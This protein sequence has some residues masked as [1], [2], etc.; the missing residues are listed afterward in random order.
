M[1]RQNWRLQ[2]QRVEEGTELQPNEW[3][4]SPLWGHDHVLGLSTD[5]LGDGSAWCGRSLA[6]A[7][8]WTEGEEWG[9]LWYTNR[10]SAQCSHCRRRQREWQGN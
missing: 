4:R 10:K 3:Y 1:G 5:L 7:R 2:A 6:V 9:G 8:D